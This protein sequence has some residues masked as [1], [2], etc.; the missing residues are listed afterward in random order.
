MIQVTCEIEPDLVGELEEHLC[1]WEVS[2]WVLV[3]NRLTGEG[4]IDGYFAVEQ[5]A[6]I[7]WASLRDVFLEL[8]EAPKVSLIEDRD[9]QEAYKE[10][11]HP[12]ETGSLHVVPAWEREGYAIPAEHNA[13]YLDPGMAF[14]TG[15]HETTRLCL[16]ALNDF[17]TDNSKKIMRL[18]CV[19]AG[20]GSGVLALAA[21]VLGF[22]EVRG[23]DLDPDAVRIAEENAAANG[24]SSQVEFACA[25]FTTALQPACADLL[26]ANVQADVLCEHRVVLLTALRPRGSLCLSGVLSKEAEEV[27]RVFAAEAKRLDLSASSQLCFDDEWASLLFQGNC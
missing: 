13:V 2:P 21:K 27:E 9:W 10:H 12:W 18:S 11:F 25:D 7:A 22:G 19:D 1:S 16:K 14:G 8:P 17:V 4:S 23:F 24:L 6:I 5:E 20:C 15:N 3:V 26:L